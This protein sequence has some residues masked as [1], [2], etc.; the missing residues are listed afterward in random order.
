MT[1]R[2]GALRRM[3]AILMGAVGALAS[4]TSRRPSAPSA[5]GEALTPT[6]DASKLLEE[7]ARLDA[8]DYSEEGIP[9]FLACENRAGGTGEGDRHPSAIPE[10]AALAMEFRNLAKLLPQIRPS[11]S[12]DDVAR[13]VEILADEDLAREATTFRP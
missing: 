12:E 11:A 6:T 7:L 4:C 9:M 2:R 10:N 13:L 5:N 8:R 1:G 3:G